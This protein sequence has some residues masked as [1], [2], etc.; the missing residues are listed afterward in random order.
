M[1]AKT[2]TS[3]EHIIAKIDNDFNFDNTDW[4][5]RVIAWC[6]D[7]MSQL[8]VLSTEYKRRKVSVNNKIV[9][10]PCPINEQGLKVYDSRGCEVDRFNSSNK[11][12]SC[13]SSTGDE[14]GEA[15]AFQNDNISNN[16]DFIENL[17]CS[18]GSNTINRTTVKNPSKALND[19]FAITVP[20]Y[21]PTEQHIVVDSYKNDVYC[22]RNYILVDDCTIELSFND[23]FIYIE[24]KELKTEYSNTYGCDVPVIP[25]NGLLIEAITYYC[26]YKIL[27]RGIKHPVFNLSANGATN[28]YTLWNTMKEK[29]KVS[30]IIDK[31]DTSN[32]DSKAWQSY[33]YNFTFPKK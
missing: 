26:V 15:A 10:L 20:T 21:T 29:A 8:K 2:N 18:N 32:N 3:V 22:D 14:Q 16:N 17:N 27:C 9:K 11:C 28:P 12:K 25:N 33:F 5:P 13:Y 19:S 7:A 31:Q 4:I 23:D 24:S 30:V 1:Q 6:I